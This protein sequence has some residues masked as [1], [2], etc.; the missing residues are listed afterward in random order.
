MSTKIIVSYDGTANEDDAIALGRVFAGAGAEV[1]LA[2]VRHSQEPDTEREELAQAEAEELLDRGAKLL[3]DPPPR[4]TSSPTARRPQGLQCARRARGR[5][6]DRVL[7]GL[8]HRQGPRR[9]RQLG[10]APARGR[11]APPS[12]SRRSAWPSSARAKAFSRS[13]RSATPTAARARPPRRSRAAL[14]ASVAPVAN[15]QTRPAGRRLASRRPSRAGLDQLIGIAPDRDR[16]LP[17]AGGAARRRAGVRP[18][19]PPGLPRSSDAAAAQRAQA[20]G[21]SSARAARPRARVPAGGASSA[22]SDDPARRRGGDRPGRSTAMP[23]DAAAAPWAGARTGLSGGT[24]SW[25][26]C[27]SL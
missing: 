13:S 5:R 4:G 15:E 9:G 18:A 12:R 21:R 24:V 6:R 27:Q 17:G 23:P 2:Y 25:R 8:A 20:R 3:G 22:S 7:L 26:A 10:P 11:L 19:R 16:H 14:G 1:S